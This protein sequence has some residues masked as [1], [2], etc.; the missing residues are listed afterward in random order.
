MCSGKPRRSRK[1]RCNRNP[2]PSPSPKHSSHGWQARAAKDIRTTSPPIR[3][4]VRRY[5]GVLILNAKTPELAAS[6]AWKLKLNP[7]GEF[8]AT[9]VPRELVCNIPQEYRNKLLSEE[10]KEVLDTKLNTAMKRR[11]LL[12]QGAAPADESP[13]TDRATPDVSQTK[14]EDAA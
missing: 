9:V 1:L 11:R 14:A 6:R 8:H 5:L 3:K 2:T 7:G 12:T 10:E 13:E 4:Q